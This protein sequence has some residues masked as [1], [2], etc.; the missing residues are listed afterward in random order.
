[1]VMKGIAVEKCEDCPLN[2]DNHCIYPDS[3]VRIIQDPK[4]MQTW[5][6]MD[7]LSI[8][9]RVRNIIKCADMIL[10]GM[11][12]H[13]LGQILMEKENPVSVLI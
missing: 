4:I 7:T 3:D 2:N 13:Q 1:M 10:T 9:I 8:T 5:C 6:P 12:T 11:G